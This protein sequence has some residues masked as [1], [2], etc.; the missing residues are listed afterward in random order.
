MEIKMISKT[1]ALNALQQ[2]KFVVVLSQYNGKILLSRHRD[3]TTWETQGG[4]IEAGETPLEAAKRELYEESG[5]VKFD[6]KPLC[7]YWAGDPGI[8]KGTNG[9]VFVAEIH[10]LDKLPESEMAEVKEFEYLPDNL[11]YPQ[12]TPVLFDRIGKAGKGLKVSEGQ[13][14]NMASLYLMNGK[15]MLFLYRVGSRVVHNTYIGSAGGHFEMDELNNAKACILRELQEEIGLTKDDLENLKLRYITLRLKNGEVRQNYY[16]FADLIDADRTLVS[17][18]GKLEWMD[19]Q[20][21]D[22]IQMPYTA[23]CV[24][25]HFVKVGKNT[26]CLYAGISTKEQ[27]DF[28]ELQEF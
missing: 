3:R 20:K 15:N 10:K 27:I 7:D 22:D 1:F 17:N 21:L 16:F 13:L 11:T 18:E 24:V 2:Y 26:D 8:N 25:Q 23:K 14:R 9:M 4:H 19:T 5:A 12:I 28:V 6:I